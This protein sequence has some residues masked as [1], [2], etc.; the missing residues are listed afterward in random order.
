MGPKPR[1]HRAR[2]KVDSSALREALSAALIR[3]VTLL[4]P[5]SLELESGNMA[6]A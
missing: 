1:G 3:L 4:Q 6:V 5:L 2:V